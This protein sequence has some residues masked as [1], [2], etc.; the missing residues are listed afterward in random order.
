MCVRHE[1]SKETRKRRTEAK[2]NKTKPRKHKTMFKTQF[3]RVR[4][5]L[6]IAALA[7]TAGVFLTPNGANAKGGSSTGGGSTKPVESRVTGYV[8]AIDYS[9][10]TITVGAS[11]Y[12]SGALKVTTS[13]SISLNNSNCDFGQLQLGDWVEARYIYTTKEATKLSA[14][15]P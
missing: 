3:K 5:A 8:T 2:R 6:F 14:T 4:R 10:N 11:Y 12:G 1:G 15:R 13:T 7:L 9:A